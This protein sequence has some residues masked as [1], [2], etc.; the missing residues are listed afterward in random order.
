MKSLQRPNQRLEGKI[1]VTPLIDVL[2]VFLI[3]FMVISP[4]QSSGLESAIPSSESVQSKP[5][6]DEAIVV[7]INADLSTQI[8]QQAILPHL[9]QQRLH[10]ILRSR[11]DR[12]V[13]L[14]AAPTLPFEVVAETIDRARGAGA[15][16]IGLLT[17]K[18]PLATA[19]LKG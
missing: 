6:P 19:R 14:Q 2:L 5:D 13:S 18:L 4:V 7:S 1:N 11:A 3:I 12:S 8:N 16:R 10:A 17:A 15:D 9:L